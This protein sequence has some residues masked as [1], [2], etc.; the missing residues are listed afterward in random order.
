MPAAQ[1]EAL[2]RVAAEKG[3]GKTR[4]NA[5]VYGT[6]RR[7]GWKPQREREEPA[8]A[9][10]PTS[11]AAALKNWRASKSPATCVPVQLSGTQ[12]VQIRQLALAAAIQYSKEKDT[13]APL[14]KTLHVAGVF[15]G[16][17]LHSQPIM[18]I[19][20]AFEQGKL[21]EA[22]QPLPPDHSTE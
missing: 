20:P 13:S 11:S 18:E 9:S 22:G 10:R 1:E 21:D 15:L 17:L 4:A 2:K 12:M 19:P 14:A 8:N 5:F 3:Y 7:L 6:L 16:W